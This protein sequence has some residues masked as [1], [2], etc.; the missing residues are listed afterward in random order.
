VNGHE[1]LDY[2]RK[3]CGLE[4]ST[5]SLTFAYW[6]KLLITLNAKLAHLGDALA[7]LGE[8]AET[9]TWQEDAT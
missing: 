9:V 4:D 6:R 5:S 1:S 2:L 8:Y 7:A 3:D